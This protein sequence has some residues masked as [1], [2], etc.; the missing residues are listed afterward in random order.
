M[1]F[2]MLYGGPTVQSR[3]HGNS[4]SMGYNHLGYFLLLMGVTLMAWG[5]VLQQRFLQRE[6]LDVPVAAK[7]FFSAHLSVLRA[8]NENCLQ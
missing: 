8:R 2:N 1:A 3:A 4:I 7:L 5:E 6:A